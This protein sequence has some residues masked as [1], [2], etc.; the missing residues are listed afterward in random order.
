MT[1]SVAVE[2]A[3]SSTER[4]SRWPAVPRGWTGPLLVSAFAGLLVFHRLGTPHAL[5]WDETYYAKDAWSFLHYGIEH[6]WRT[7]A[8]GDPA[9]AYFLAGH[10]VA[11]LAGGAEWAAHPPLGKWLI[12]AGMAVFGSGPFGYRSAA[13]AAGVLAVLLLARIARRMTGSTV[14]GCAAG[15][16]L[17]LDGSWLVSSRVSMLDIFLLVWVLAGFG[18]LL[19]DRD[20][21]RAALAAGASFVPH[22][23]RVAA[24][25]CFGLACATKWSGAYAMLFF[26]A[27][28]LVWDRNA[29]KEAGVAKPWRGMAKLDLPV[30]L[31]QVWVA[32]GLVYAAS[33]W[34]WFVSGT[35]LQKRL[36]GQVVP[37]F[38]RNWAE[39]HPSA[40]WP[41]FLDPVRSLWHYHAMTLDFHSGVTGPNP[42]QSWPWQWPFLGH[43]AVMWRTPV[44]QGQDGCHAVKCVS[45]I[46]H[47]GTPMIWWFSV[48]ALL[49]MLFCAFYL[50][51]WRAVTAAGGYLAGWLPWF[52]AALDDRTMYS[53]YALP[54]LPF[55]I[56]AIVLLFEAVYVPFRDRPV[57]RAVIGAAGAAYLAVVAANLLYLHPILTG[58]ALPE[59]DRL[60]RLWFSGWT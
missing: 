30:S 55:A 35:S 46:S 1:A 44:P 53:T 5:V 26:W 23:W 17:A 22:G 10:P 12:A 37:G 9:N 32:A 15:L 16:L 24:G 42:G 20:R 8:D 6:N 33:W 7:G 38:Q 56:L 52:P 19:I 39:R 41:D 18:C 51:D 36:F 27:L 29:R 50:R 43:P 47:L 21:T 4:P 57:P 54:M 14:L 28:A 40:I 45:E 34:G 31:L 13:A 11:G 58:T 48:V 49:A 25:V 3:A 2:E 59:A 60:A